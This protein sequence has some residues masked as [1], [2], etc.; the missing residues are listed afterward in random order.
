MK[1]SFIQFIWRY[2]RIEQHQLWS[3]QREAIQI[4]DFGQYNTNAG[5][6]FLQAKIKIGD[7]LWAGQVEMHIKASDWYQHRHD[8]D[9]AYQNVILHVVWEADTEI[10]RTDGQIIPCLELKSITTPALY[11]RYLKL[12]RHPGRIPC[13]D[14]IRE[15]A[16]IKIKLWLDRLLVERLDQKTRYWREA[17]QRQKNDWEQVFFQALAQSMGLPVNKDAMEALATRT[18]LL[19][20]QKHR[21]QLFQ[22]EALLFGQAGMLEEPSLKDEYPQK[23]RREYQFLRKKYQLQPLSPLEWKFSRMRPSNF[24]TIRIAQLALL[25]HQSNYLFSKIMALQ[26]VDEAY[27]ALEVKTSY[28]WKTHYRFD[29]VSAQRREKKLGRSTIDLMLINTIIPFIFLYGK[30]MALPNYTERALHLLE[31]IKPENNHLIRDWA[32]RG[33]SAE[34]ACQSQGL[35]HLYKH[36]CQHKRCLDCAIG[37]AIITGTTSKPIDT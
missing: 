9:P 11:Q 7:T 14:S 15:V 19:L 27:H 33:I 26:S 34:N 28:Y 20:L 35:M 16:D 25:V 30:N 3:T 23:L 12:A 17:L 31:Q 32:D 22:L 2:R 37:N 13:Q 18:P 24:P 29:Q 10:R 21:D 8:Q 6:D 5:P 4:I 1:E 36:Y